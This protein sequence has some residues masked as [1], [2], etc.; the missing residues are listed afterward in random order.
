MVFITNVIT[1]LFLS[2]SFGRNIPEFSPTNKLSVFIRST[3]D[4]LGS[5]SAIKKTTFFLLN[6][7][8][9]DSRRERDVA[10]FV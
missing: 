8:M 5:A 7:V 1:V 2:Y 3:N 10:H 6:C 4:I 9:Y